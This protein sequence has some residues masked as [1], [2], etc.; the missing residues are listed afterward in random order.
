MGTPDQPVLDCST[1]YYANPLRKSCT[2][3]G[4]GHLGITAHSARTGFATDSVVNRAPFSDIKL[5]IRWS[6]D[7]NVKVYLD[8]IMSRAMFSVPSVPKCRE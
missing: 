6:S 5:A 2:R 8:A 7:S 1:T 3:L 4:T